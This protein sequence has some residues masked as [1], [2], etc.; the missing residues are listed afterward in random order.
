MLELLDIQIRVSYKL[1][2]QK[3]RC[4]IKG[5]LL[6]LSYWEKQKQKYNVCFQGDTTSQSILTE[7]CE[8]VI[9]VH[10]TL[11]VLTLKFEPGGLLVEY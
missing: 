1:A 10:Q 8:I 2:S 5:V 9:L 4:Y 6:H 3:Q 7:F 11:A